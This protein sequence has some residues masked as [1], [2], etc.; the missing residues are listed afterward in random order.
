MERGRLDGERRERRG[1]LWSGRGRREGDGGGGGR[2]V[3]EW[4]E[5]RGSVTEER[6]KLGEGQGHEGRRK[7]EME[8]YG[9]KKLGGREG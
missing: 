9:A 2:S 8:Y 7:I 6:W 5:R 3:R 1:V 4:K